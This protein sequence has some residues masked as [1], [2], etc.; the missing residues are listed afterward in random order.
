MLDTHQA[1]AELVGRRL[2]GAAGERLPANL[3]ATT[4]QQGFDIQ[5]EVSRQIF[6]REGHGIGGWKCLLP[7]EGQHIVAPIYSDGICTTSPCSLNALAGKAAIEPEF[8]FVFDAALPSR[9]QAYSRAEVWGAVAGVHMALEL[10]K[11]RFDQPDQCEFPELLADGLFNQGLFLG[12]KVHGLP[13][14]SM[15]LTFAA[16]DQPPR[17]INGAHP[18]QDPFGPIVWLANFL[19]ERGLGLQAGQ[20]VITGSYAGVLNAPFGQ[21]ITLDYGDLGSLSTKFEARATP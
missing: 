1:A 20:A 10:I 13:P 4:L 12:P 2:A 9:P 6:Q 15:D 18:N 14:P 7:P 11:S 5:C 3:R 17:S 21:D 16:G 8:A 19:S